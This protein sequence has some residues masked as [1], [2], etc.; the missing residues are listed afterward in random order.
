MIVI[1]AAVPRLSTGDPGRSKI[2]VTCWKF[3]RTPRELES[4]LR[5]FR[6]FLDGLSHVAPIRSEED[7]QTIS[8][9][10]GLNRQAS[11][12]R[13]LESGDD[14]QGSLLNPP[15]VEG[16]DPVQD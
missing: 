8:T 13:E 11:L 10:V 12:R 15:G 16:S 7:A 4:I 14:P 9:S 6:E 1:K 2:P 3:D 5:E